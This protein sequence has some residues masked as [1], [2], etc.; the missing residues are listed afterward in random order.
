[1]GTRASKLFKKFDFT[2]GDNIP[3]VDIIEK[4]LAN[5]KGYS[6]IENEEIIIHYPFKNL[7]KINYEKTTFNY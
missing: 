4:Y 6:K 2:D 1:M 5:T 7:K 3:T